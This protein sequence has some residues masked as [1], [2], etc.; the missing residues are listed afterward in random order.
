[1]IA[2]FATS[3]D[4]KAVQFAPSNEF[5]IIRRLNDVRGIKFTGVLLFPCSLNTR[6]KHDAL[7]ALKIHQPELFK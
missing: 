2:V 6:E 7:E 3:V 1:M 4:I 5:R